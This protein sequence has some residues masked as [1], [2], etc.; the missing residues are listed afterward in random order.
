LSRYENG[1]ARF[2]VATL[3]KLATAL[4]CELL[5]QL[6]PKKEVCRDARASQVVAQLGR[7]FW[8]VPLREE[9]LEENALWV[10]ERVLELGALDDIHLLTGFFGR[11]ALL[12]LVC[13]SRFSSERTRVFWE[14]VLDREGKTCT[15]RSFP[16]EAAT[17]WR[18]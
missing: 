4:R 18:S 7:L 14:Q 6:E 2:E 13:V 3:Q 17:S 8:D 10:V 1:W 12:E 15:K 11:E 9:H 5:V 16:R